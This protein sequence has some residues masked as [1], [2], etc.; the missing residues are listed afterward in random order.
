[1]PDDELSKLAI[2]KKLRNKVVLNEQ[3]DRM[4]KDERAKAFVTIFLLHG[5]AL[6][7]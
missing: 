1:M 4:L 3:V 2:E 5:Y 7:N 6:I